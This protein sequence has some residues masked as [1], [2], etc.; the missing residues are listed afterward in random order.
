MHSNKKIYSL[1]YSQE[2]VNIWVE[3]F[4]ENKYKDALSLCKDQK[5]ISVI[6]GCVAD[7]IFE[8]GNYERSVDYYAKSN[9]SFEEV[10]LKFLN[11]NLH[12]HL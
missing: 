10:A 5:Y 12:S 8:A 2:K 7:Q 6:S 9:R 3:Y 1:D 11:K 4:K